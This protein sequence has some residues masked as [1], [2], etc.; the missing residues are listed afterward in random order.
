MVRTEKQP[1]LEDIL[2]CREERAIHQQQLLAR[3]QKPIISFTIN[4][5]G[6]VKLCAQSRY[7][8]AR[9]RE[10]LEQAL[11]RAGIS[12]QHREARAP[13]G[14]PEVFYVL[15]GDASAIKEIACMVEDSLPL[16]RLFDMDVLVP[17]GVGAVS[18][19]ETGRTRRGCLVCG[20]LGP[21]CASSRA[22]SVE[23]LLERIGALVLEDKKARR[24]ALRHSEAKKGLENLD[25]LWTPE[26]FGAL[27]VRAL[28]YELSATPKPGLVDRANCGSH[29]DMN[30]FTFL[31]SATALYPYFTAAAKMGAEQAGK[32]PGTLFRELRPLGMQ[33]EQDMLRATG[34]VNTHKGAVFTLGL[35][36]AA[37]G[38]FAA[39][40]KPLE[41][42]RLCAYVGKMT[43]GLCGRELAGLAEDKE[44]T[45]GERLYR[46]HG[47]TGI[48]GEAEAGLPRVWEIGYP[49]LE[50]SLLTGGAPLER[51]LLHTLLYLMAAV[52]DTNVMGRNGKTAARY[53]KGQAAMLTE[54]GG[55]LS[56]DGIARLEHMDKD[57]IA[58]NISP[59]GSADL[60]AAALLL[61][62]LRHPEVK[63]AD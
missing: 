43:A 20:V 48:R 23:E 7:I 28:L 63:M 13:L 36:C 26:R 16:G 1:A 60:L 2:R 41:P 10:E 38:S 57:F 46:E 29:S 27:A 58:R 8:A 45:K 18:R 33:A 55:A 42:K 31:D 40:G 39:R 17:G 11:K 4:M 59:G 49:V 52:E 3:Y 25:I 53:V 22:H 21:A 62:F 19:V 5:P 61:F 47:V 56:A 14:G 34:G 54:C 32:R 9:G 24:A 50:S 30:Y 44:L 35:L 12:V 15:D 37:A 6:P 51:C